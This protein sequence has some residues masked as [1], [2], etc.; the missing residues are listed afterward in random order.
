MATDKRERLIAKSLEDIP[1]AVTERE[2]ELAHFDKLVAEST[3]KFI[4][5]LSS[6]LGC[7]ING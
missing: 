7:E 1:P 2:K 3:F 6:S 5:S 4:L